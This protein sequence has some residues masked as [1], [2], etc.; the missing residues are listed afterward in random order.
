M[1]D[2]KDYDQANIRNTRPKYSDELQFLERKRDHLEQKPPIFPAL[3][4]SVTI[5]SLLVPD[6]NVQYLQILF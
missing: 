6:R 1:S 3:D 5:G 4:I 2:K